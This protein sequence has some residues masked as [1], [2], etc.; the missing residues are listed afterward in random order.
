MNLSL[1]QSEEIIWSHYWD[2]LVK[3]ISE[4]HSSLVPSESNKKTSHV[5]MCI[6]RQIVMILELTAKQ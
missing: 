6:Q 1:P 3:M 5:Q 4:L 2:E